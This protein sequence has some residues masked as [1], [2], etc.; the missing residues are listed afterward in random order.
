[1]KNLLSKKSLAMV[2][3]I[4]AMFSIINSASAACIWAENEEGTGYCDERTIN[5]GFGEIVIS[6]NCVEPIPDSEEDCI[7]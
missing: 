2:F 4:V 3:A 1:M 7:L 5:L 6:V